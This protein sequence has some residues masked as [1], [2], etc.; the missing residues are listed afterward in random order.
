MARKKKLPPTPI[1]EELA[2]LIPDPKDRDRLAEMLAAEQA[3]RVEEGIKAEQ[4][5]R[6]EDIVRTERQMQSLER[7]IAI[8]RETRDKLERE[9]GAD[10]AHHK[11]IGKT[12]GILV[13]L[14]IL[15]HDVGEAG[16]ASQATLRRWLRVASQFR[17]AA[18]IMETMAGGC[19]GICDAAIATWEKWEADD[20]ATES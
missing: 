10:E 7:R 17:D 12:K 19:D 13:E 20:D 11:A 6:T 3:E 16:G 2:R 18:A 5:R 8:L 9:V 15:L 1:T 4:R 14:S